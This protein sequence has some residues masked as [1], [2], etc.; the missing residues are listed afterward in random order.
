MA[1]LRRVTVELRSDA[2]RNRE[3]LVASARRLFAERGVDVPV[4]DITQDAGL[5]M[6]TLYRH[7][8]AKED[9]IDAVLEHA[10]EEYFALAE[11]GLEQ[12]DAWVG[13]EVFRRR[14][15]RS[16][17]EPG[18]GRSRRA[19]GDGDAEAPEAEAA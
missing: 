9:L 15:C 3:L 1:S 4:E 7:F 13:L 11:A 18:P 19:P 6:G 5:G 12:D 8:P 2:R 14:A 16:R 10:F 17:R